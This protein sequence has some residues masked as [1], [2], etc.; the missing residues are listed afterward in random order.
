MGQ[1][2]SFNRKGSRLV[3]VAARWV[4]VVTTILDSFQM[5]C[6]FNIAHY[7]NEPRQESV[8]R[9]VPLRE[10]EALLSLAADSGRMTGNPEVI[11]RST[12]WG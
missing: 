3:E 2:L 11:R 5:C 6:L 9:Q 10:L 8:A 4:F 1:R 12:G 7:A